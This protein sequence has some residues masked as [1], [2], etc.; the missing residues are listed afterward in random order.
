MSGAKASQALRTWAEVSF[1]V[2]HCLQMGLFLRL[3]MLCPVRRPITTLDS[4]LLNDNNHALVAK[5]CH[6]INSRAC[7]RVLQEPRH[8]TKCC[9]SIHRC[10][11]LLMFCVDTHQKGSGRTSFWTEQSLVSL[12][13]VLFPRTPACPGTQ[14]NPTVCPVWRVVVL[15]S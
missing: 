9:L 4:V 7:L 6:E 10:T 8:I 13:A 3:R 11:C 15:I 1:T 2:P 12:S 5:L 14:S